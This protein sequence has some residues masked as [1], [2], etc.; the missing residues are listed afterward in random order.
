MW[1]IR[2]RPRKTGK[3][4]TKNDKIQM[5]NLN[6]FKRRRRGKCLASILTFWAEKGIFRSFPHTCTEN[7]NTPIYCLRFPIIIKY[8]HSHGINNG[9]EKFFKWVE[10]KYMEKVN[11]IYL[12]SVKRSRPRRRQEILFRRWLIIVKKKLCFICVYYYYL[13]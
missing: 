10:C 3:K 13:V 12:S 1:S 7:R 5:K 6:K 9:P 8:K 4:S 11:V 2:P